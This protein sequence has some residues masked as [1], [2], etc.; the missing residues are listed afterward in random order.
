MGECS[1]QPGD[2]RIRYEDAAVCV[3]TLRS[4]ELGFAVRRLLLPGAIIILLLLVSC[5]NDVYNAPPP[6]EIGC[7]GGGIAIQEPASTDLYTTATATVPLAGIVNANYP[8]VVWSNSA[9]GDSGTA[10]LSNYR[11]TCPLSI[12]FYIWDWYASSPIPLATG[13]NP[14]TADAYDV[15]GVLNAR[16]CITITRTGP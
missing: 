11:L 7:T 9:T 15:D 14:V 4:D 5:S 10:V 6:A 2:G 16:A 1:L 12:C 13:D 8:K 3:R